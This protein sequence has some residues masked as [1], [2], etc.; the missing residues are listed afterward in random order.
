MLAGFDVNERRGEELRQ[1]LYRHTARVLNHVRELGLQTPNV[2][3]TP[4]IELPLASSEMVDVVTDI[5]WRDGIYVT[6][7]AYPL[8]PRDQVGFRIQLTAN[9]TDEEIDG[10]LKT[11][12][13]LA[14]E[15]M[16]RKAPG[17]EA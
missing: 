3:G 9:H 15:G 2:I 7:A 5:L 17:G 12:E 6:V 8:V 4:I 14:G 16:L 13:T 11:I 1:S 10:L